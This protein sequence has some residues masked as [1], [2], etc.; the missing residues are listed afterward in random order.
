MPHLELP[1]SG[2][3]CASCSSRLQRALGAV[4]GVEDASVN[5]VTERASVS[6][7]D[8]RSAG[9][10]V[11]AVRDAGF[12]VPPQTARLSVEGMTCATCSGRV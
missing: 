4:D 2:M 12:D 10:V 6:L 3:T 11:E 9:P 1:I 7:L 5:L 8:G